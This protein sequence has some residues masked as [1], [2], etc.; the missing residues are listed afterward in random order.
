MKGGDKE[1]GQPRLWE[2]EDLKAVVL[3]SGGIDSSTTLAIAK[4]EGYDLY[5]MTIFYGQTHDREIEA[6][7]NVAKD[8]GVKEHRTIEF[9]K[10]VFKGSALTG[11]SEIPLDRDPLHLDDI[12]A[13]YVPAWYLKFLSMASGWAE[14]IGADAV[15]I[16]ATALDYSGYPDCRPEFIGSFEMTV[17]LATKRGVEG[18]PIKIM[19]PLIDM[20]K[21]QIISKG[22]ELGLD[23]GSTWSCYSGGERACGRCDSCLYRLKGFQEAGSED[24]IDYLEVS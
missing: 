9:P 16:G 10:G 18:D 8:I 19:A 3:L 4:S 23:Y 21:A 7:K 14:V 1:P 22:I 5:A 15:F 17:N 24:P 2:S 12:P 20:T 6:A 13:T 11:D